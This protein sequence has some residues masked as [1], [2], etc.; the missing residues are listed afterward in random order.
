MIKR[1]QV[2]NLIER[3]HLT[4]PTLIGPAKD[5]ALGDLFEK[6]IDYLVQVE[7][8]NTRMKLTKGLAGLAQ[9]IKKIKEDGEAAYLLQQ[10]IKR[11]K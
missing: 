6:S 10:G 3:L 9:K 11:L 5:M 8:N 7:K 4:Q 1:D 2:F